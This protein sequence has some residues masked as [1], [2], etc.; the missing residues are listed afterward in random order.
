MLTALA[1]TALL[2]QALPGGL[3]VLVTGIAGSL[4]G[5]SLTRN[6][7]PPPERHPDDA[8]REVA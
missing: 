5:A 3:P 8:V 6:N 2:A 1:S 7:P 4:L